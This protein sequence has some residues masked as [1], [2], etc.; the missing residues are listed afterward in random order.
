MPTTNIVPKRLAGAEAKVLWETG[1]IRGAIVESAELTGNGRIVFR[2]GMT[3]G[4]AVIGLLDSRGVCIWS[5]HIWS[6]DYEIEATAQTYASGAVFMDRNLGALATD[7]TQAAA[8]RTLLPVGPQRSVSVS[9]AGHG[10][11]HAGSLTVYAPGSSM[12]KAIPNLRN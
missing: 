11:L 2:T 10:R 7:C 12:L 4:N 9:S 6:V 1:T 8:Q 5:W 3:Y